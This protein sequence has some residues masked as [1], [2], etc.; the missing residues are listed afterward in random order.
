MHTPRVET[1]LNAS[2]PSVC[3]LSESTY[4]KP[5][6]STQRRKFEVLSQAV[7]AFVIGRSVDRHFHIFRE[8][9]HFYLFPEPS[10]RAGRYLFRT[11][12]QLLLT[13]WCLIR[14]GANVV[15]AQS[16]YEAFVGAVAKNIVRV[17][18]KRVAL[19]VE[20]HGD[21]VVSPDMQQTQPLPKMYRAIMRRATRFGLKRADIFRSVSDSTRYQILPWAHGKQIF[22][23]PTWTDIEIFIDE[24]KKPRPEDS[25]DV[26]F[27]G[28]VIPRKG[29]IHLVNSFGRVSRSY[30]R[31]R[32][33]IVGPIL[34]PLYG[35]A[36][37]RRI[38]DAD[39]VQRCIRIEWVT[40]TR[41]AS[42]M[43]SAGLF[44]L[45]T[46]SEGQPRVILEA[47]ATGVPVIASAVSGIPEV[48]SDRQT[49]VLIPPGDEVELEGALRWVFDNRDLA[50]EI[51]ARGQKFARRFL[52][53]SQYFESYQRMFDAAI[54]LTSST[55]IRR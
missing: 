46:Y 9:A 39:L 35:E 24:G 38:A 54:A 20:N 49:G 51:G 23:F 10:F 5:L 53:T 27:A 16:P 40:Q 45:P 19:I 25:Q 22:Q 31:A 3:F 44:V 1:R 6:D 34:D 26:L 28:V 37:A 50:E 32:L 30:P 15:I 17:W 52:S 7:Q 8:E 36:I 47:L 41:L 29:V 48:I 11:A 2:L 21:F 13:L 55:R 43:H 18:R 42:L 12:A 14:G 4:T 33:V